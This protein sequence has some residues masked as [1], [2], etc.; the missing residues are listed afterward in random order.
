MIRGTTPKHTFTIP[1]DAENVAEVMIIYAQDDAEVFHKETKDCEMTGRTI[2]VTLS[3]EDT[4]LFDHTRNAQIQLR[5][6]TTEGV[7]LA[8][9]IIVLT[10]GKLLSDEV[11]Y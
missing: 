10:V 3:Q 2:S 5:L 11:I 7:A 6:L 4:L 8:S 1:L 9:H